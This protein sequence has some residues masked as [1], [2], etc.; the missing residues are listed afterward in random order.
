MVAAVH[1]TRR[2][3]HFFWFDELLTSTAAI[4]IHATNTP[5][6]HGPRIMNISVMFNSFKWWL[7]QC[8][9][10][11]PP[12]SNFRVF[13]DLIFSQTRWNHHLE[14]RYWAFLCYTWC[15]DGGSYRPYFACNQYLPG[16]WV[17]DKL[18]DDHP[19]IHHLHGVSRDKLDS[20]CVLILSDGEWLTPHSVHM[21]MTRSASWIP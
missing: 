1:L 13:S 16:P 10:V 12:L 17:H 3:H 8:S 14:L 2:C 19:V 5:E 21:R 20:D 11:T 9:T 7:C 18:T 6:P 4:A 15:I